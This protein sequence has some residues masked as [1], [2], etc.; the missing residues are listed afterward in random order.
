MAP[1]ST[2]GSGGDQAGA[3]QPAPILFRQAVALMQSG[4]YQAA[5]TTLERVVEGDDGLPGAWT[6]LGIAYAHLGRVEDAETALER[7]IGME[8][9]N[10]VAHN[11]LGIL[12]RRAGR[13]EEAEAA[14]QQAL[15]VNRSYAPA[16]LNIGILCEIYLRD[17]ACALRHYRQY[18]QLADEPAAPVADWIAVLEQ[19]GDMP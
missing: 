17:D 6:N 2:A 19:R 11:E 5:A 9:N 3:T 8:P 7:V 13:L 10:V 16:H 12:Y 14:Y 18:L 1:G 4:D 15:S